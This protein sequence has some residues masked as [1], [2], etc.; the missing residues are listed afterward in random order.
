MPVT[1]VVGMSPF[2]YIPN[3]DLLAADRRAAVDR[4]SGMGRSGQGAT[5]GGERQTD[6]RAG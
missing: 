6:R 1:S 5:P 3:R 4:G 2:Y